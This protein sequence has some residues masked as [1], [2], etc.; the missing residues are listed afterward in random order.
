MINFSQR[1]GKALSRAERSVVNSVLHQSLRNVFV[2][3]CGES[4]TKVFEGSFVDCARRRGNIDLGRYWQGACFNLINMKAR[5]FEGEIT[6]KYV[7]WRDKLCYYGNKLLVQKR[8]IKYFTDF[9]F[10]GNTLSH[11]EQCPRQTM[12]RK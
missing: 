4:T 6:N 9:T 8:T 2:F 5:I 1:D 10:F 11:L 3:S 7:D 12:I